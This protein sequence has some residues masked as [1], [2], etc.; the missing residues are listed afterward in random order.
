MDDTAS[1]SALDKIA[2]AIT[3]ISAIPEPVQLPMLP[4]PAKQDEVDGLMLIISVQL[5]K[6]PKRER[7]SL[8]FEILSF[9]NDKITNIPLLQ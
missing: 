9:V 2:D 1:T 8:I 3:T 4:L 6:L 7:R 5:R